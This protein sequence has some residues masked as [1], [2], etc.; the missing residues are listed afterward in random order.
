MAAIPPLR[1]NPET[2]DLSYGSDMT[3]AYAVR[4]VQFGDGYAQRAKA[5]LNNVRQQWRLMWTGLP[6]A[7]AETLRLFFR[8]LAGVGLVDWAP[9]NQPQN[10]PLKWT[11]TGWS[12]KPSGFK[13]QDCSI[14]LTQEFDL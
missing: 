2:L 1:G 6:D 14:T 11:A 4:R 3:E 8:Q 13:V 7:D 5:G 9:Y 10:Q 12:A